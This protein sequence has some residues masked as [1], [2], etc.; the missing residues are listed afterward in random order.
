MC[1]HFENELLPGCLFFFFNV[2]LNQF[3]FYGHSEK[4]KKTDVFMQ[5]LC[6]FYYVDSIYSFKVSATFFFFITN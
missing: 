5:S 4:L 6:S 3:G 1:F 2:F